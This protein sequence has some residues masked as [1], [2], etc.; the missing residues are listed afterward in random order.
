MRNLWKIAICG[1]VIPILATGC[2]G[3]IEG[4]PIVLKDESVAKP[5]VETAE[6]DPTNWYD[7][8]NW[9]SYEAQDNPLKFMDV[10][11]PLTA[12]NIAPIIE[13]C[14]ITTHSTEHD[15]DVVSPDASQLGSDGIVAGDGHLKIGGDAYEIDFFNETEM[16]FKEAFEE[17]HFQLYTESV[18][19]SKL[20]IEAKESDLD[21]L[22]SV[23]DLYGAPSFVVN[24]Q[25]ITKKMN[26]LL[27]WEREGYYFGFLVSD[28]SYNSN[29]PKISIQTFEYFG[30]TG[31][32]AYQNDPYY[33]QTY[34]FWTFNEFLS[35]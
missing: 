6:Y 27:I 1:I 23:C 9:D 10:E 35:Q 18:D 28:E 3:N 5:V 14:S 31:W 2:G 20:G 33:A 32:Y 11:A 8:I 17:G 7:T 13:N 26:P 34:D 4:S 30:E 12:G 22:K 19:W 25:G 21:N 29:T 24:M 16:T 15:L